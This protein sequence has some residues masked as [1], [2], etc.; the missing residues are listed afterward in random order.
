MLQVGGEKERKSKR[1]RERK[2][3]REK[4]VCAELGNYESGGF[5]NG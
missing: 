1:K 2:G 3:R 5:L 4:D